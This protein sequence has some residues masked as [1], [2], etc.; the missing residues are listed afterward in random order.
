MTLFSKDHR[1]EGTGGVIRDHKGHWV[2]G[3]YHSINAQNHTR[4]KLEALLDNL[5]IAAEQSI[6]PIEIEL[7]SIEEIEAL[8]DTQP[9]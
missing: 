8:E 4:A 7:D 2:M 5:K 9:I 1:K 3:F 6:A